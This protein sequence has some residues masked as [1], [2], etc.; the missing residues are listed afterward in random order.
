M[1]RIMFWRPRSEIEVWLPAKHPLGEDI[2]A[3][4]LA[5]RHSVHLEPFPAS[6]ELFQRLQQ[7]FPGSH[8]NEYGQLV[9]SDPL[10]NGFVASRGDQ[11]VTVG[12]FELEEEDFDRVFEIAGEFDC[13]HYDGGN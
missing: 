4:V 9:W 7:A 3:D 6:A 11:Y 10:D 5:G 8:M 1:H 13:S 2:R 12:C